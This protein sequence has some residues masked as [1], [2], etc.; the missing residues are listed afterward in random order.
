MYSIRKEAGVSQECVIPSLER[1]RTHQRPCLEP[2]S[3]IWTATQIPKHRSAP[4]PQLAGQSCVW[5][6]AS[7]LR[8]WGREYTVACRRDNPSAAVVVE[9]SCS[10]DGHSRLH[11]RTLDSRRP[12]VDG[13]KDI[14]PLRGT[15][16]FDDGTTGDVIV[17]SS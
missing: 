11:N 10:V 9:R 12:N 5:G 14:H 17:V 1:K 6:M 16:G 15:T 4:G 7:T 8:L 3:S 2:K 13:N